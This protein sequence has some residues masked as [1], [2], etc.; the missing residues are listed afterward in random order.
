MEPSEAEADEWFDYVFQH[1]YNRLEQA[2]RRL[3]NK[4]GKFATS[5]SF[6]QGEGF[7]SNYVVPE[8]D[9]AMEFAISAKNFALVDE[10]FSVDHWLR[11]L[12]KLAGTT[13]AS[14][15]DNMDKALDRIRGSQHISVVI[16]KE[17][18]TSYKAYEMIAKRKIFAS[19]IEAESFSTDLR[20]K[21]GP[22]YHLILQMYDSHCWDLWQFLQVVHDYRRKHSIRPPPVRRENICI[23]CKTKD[24]VFDHVE[25]TLPESL[26][27]EYRV[28]PRGYVCGNCKLALDDL[29]DG[30]SEMLPFSSTLVMT[31][32]GGKKGKLPA[33]KSGVLHM[34]KKSPNRIAL[35]AFS[36]TSEIKPE[37]LEGG[38]FKFSI[39]IRDRKFDVHKIARIIYKAALAEIALAK[40]REDVL[41]KHFDGVRRYVIHGGT[42]P[43]NMFMFNEGDPTGT[44]EAHVD[45]LAG[46][47]RADFVILG[48]RFIVLLGESPL[49]EP[50]ESLKPLVTIFNLSL[51]NPRTQPNKG[52]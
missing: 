41:G 43:N 33:L 7:R 30:I 52:M 1:N 10:P 28:L 20:S 39:T 26:G 31:S 45:N 34:K 32:T 27:N 14:E 4:G 17:K 29:E 48:F 47:P 40:S 23:F 24:G 25:H 12:R 21:V 37:P 49:I 42:F 44:I 8:D 36:K 13:H 38:G 46:I 11:F 18:I 50:N 6:K 5:I 9:A 15:F 22:V 51:E 16:D 35:T 19:D 2:A 3:A